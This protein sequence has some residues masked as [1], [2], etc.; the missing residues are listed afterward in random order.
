[1][2]TVLTEVEAQASEARAVAAKQ[3]KRLQRRVDKRDEEIALLRYL[4]GA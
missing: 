4:P 2:H 3:V 1:M